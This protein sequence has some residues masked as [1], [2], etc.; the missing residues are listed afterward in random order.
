MYFLSA[1][2]AKLVLREAVESLIRHSSALFPIPVDHE[3][4]AAI[5]ESAAIERTFVQIGNC[6]ISS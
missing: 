3:K 5:P 2:N 4:F 6:V 1:K